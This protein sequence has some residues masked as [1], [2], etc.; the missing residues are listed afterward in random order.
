MEWREVGQ[1]TMV[2]QGRMKK[3]AYAMAFLAIYYSLPQICWEKDFECIYRMGIIKSL[4]PYAKY[5]DLIVI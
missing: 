1:W 5:P 4:K 3:F 2:E